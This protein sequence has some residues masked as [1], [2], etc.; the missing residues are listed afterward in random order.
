MY[1]IDKNNWP[2]GCR[3]YTI[4]KIIDPVTVKSTKLTKES[5]LRPS[6]T[7]KL[8]KEIKVQVMHPSIT[9]HKMT[10]P[11]HHPPSS[12][13]LIESNMADLLKLGSH[14]NINFTPAVLRNI[15]GLLEI[16][17]SPLA[18]YELLK[19]I[20]QAPKSHTSPSVTSRM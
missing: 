4:D 19:K 14:L 10:H 2:K 3:E 20:L 18:V 9:S 15:L 6:K 13:S 7:I 16:G 11:H 8:T 12:S 1:K 5:T 17:Y